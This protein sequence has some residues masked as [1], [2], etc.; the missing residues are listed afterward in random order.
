MGN[1]VGNKVILEQNKEETEDS[2][3]MR[4]RT[5][6][7]GSIGG[8]E[9]KEKNV[10]FKLH[11]DDDK[12]GCGYSSKGCTRIRIVLTQ[13]EL[14]QILNDRS[15][16]SSM[17]QFLDALNLKSRKVS[18]VGTSDEGTR[19]GWRPDLETIVEDH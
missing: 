1:C 18:S 15:K 9:I 4:S 11:E 19:R 5:S 13:S 2:R 12:S 14:S 3:R 8:G 17:E 10:R 6:S 7:A 16:Y